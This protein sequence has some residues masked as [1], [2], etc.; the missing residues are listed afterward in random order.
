MRVLIEQLVDNKLHELRIKEKAVG[1]LVKKKKRGTYQALDEC[2]KDVSDIKK[3]LSDFI[4]D[5]LIYE[6]M[7]GKI[8]KMFEE[9][10]KT[11]LIVEVSRRGWDTVVKDILNPT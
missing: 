6:L 7:N 9:E 8:R 1:F 2:S 10:L 3:F 4:E 5:W 11:Q